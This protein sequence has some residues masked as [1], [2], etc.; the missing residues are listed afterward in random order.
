M[1]ACAAIIAALLALGSWAWRTARRMHCRITNFLDD[2]S[3][4]AARPGVHSRPGVM[5]RLAD[6]DSRIERVEQQ[7]VTNGGAS[8][9]DAVDRIEDHLG[10]Q[11]GSVCV[12]FKPIERIE[13][14]DPQ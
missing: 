3:G 7:L 8:M 2:W 6:V 13:R 9:R 5:E 11:L 12:N 4:E 10:T 14:K 1:G